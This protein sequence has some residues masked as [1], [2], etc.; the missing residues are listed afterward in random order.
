MRIS[1]RGGFTSLEDRTKSRGRTVACQAALR[2]RGEAI[3][4]G[5]SRSIGWIRLA[6]GRVGNSARPRSF[7]ETR[8][9]ARRGEVG[10]R[11]RKKRPSGSA[12]KFGA[13]NSAR[14]ISAADL[15]KSTASTN[16]SIALRQRR[17]QSA[18][19]DAEREMHGYP[20]SP[21]SD[22]HTLAFGCG[23]LRRARSLDA[24][25]IEVLG[26]RTRIHQARAK[27]SV[28]AR[29]TRRVAR[30]A[31]RH[32]HLGRRAPAGPAHRG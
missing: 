21:T 27:G 20:I 19:C 9:C 14:F 18:P 29:S 8:Y 25:Q 6:C 15:H 22:R 31:R 10:D 28:S 23:P 30:R 7:D 4:S 1:T 3:D 11:K 26:W 16:A 32:Q 2:R 13:L 17:A 24:R 5:S 12:P